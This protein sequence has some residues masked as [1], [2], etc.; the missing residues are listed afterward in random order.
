MFSTYNAIWISKPCSFLTMYYPPKRNT[1]NQVLIS[2]LLGFLLEVHKGAV[3]YTLKERVQV[4]THDCLLL[5][6]TH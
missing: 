5:Q 6:L 2:G 4:F 3:L 1:W